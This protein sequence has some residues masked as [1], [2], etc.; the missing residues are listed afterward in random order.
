MKAI[1][2][3]GLLAG[4]VPGTATFTSAS[5]NTASGQNHGI[6]AQISIAR[7]GITA[8]A[9]RLTES[10]SSLG[11]N[12][13]GLRI[14]RRARLHTLGFGMQSRVC[15]TGWGISTA[16]RWRRSS[17]CETL[18]D[19]PICGTSNGF[20]GGGGGRAQLD[21][22]CCRRVVDSCR[23]NPIRPTTDGRFSA[24]R[25]GALPK[26]LTRSTACEAVSADKIDHPRRRRYENAADAFRDMVLRAASSLHF[27]AS[28]S[29]RGRKRR[30]LPL[31]SSSEGGSPQFDHKAPDVGVRIS[32]HPYCLCLALVRVT[33]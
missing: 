17:L 2:S 15:T 30:D 33:R 28:E 22:S 23:Q 24:F 18:N 27:T 19:G 26:V 21:Q 13:M 25:G 11:V 9:Y 1:S 3:S 31:G 10:G 32:G 12:A 7:P 6:W 8:R 14:V 4:Q 16:S 29:L 5:I 20:G